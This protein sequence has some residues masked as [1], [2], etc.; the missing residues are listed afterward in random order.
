MKT[1]LIWWYIIHGGTNDISLNKV[2]TLRP[3]NLPMEI[4]DIY[5]ICKSFGIARI[6]NS[7]ILPR[8]DLE[9]LKRIDE[10]N[11][12]LKDLCGFYS[13][14]FIDNS[15]ITESNSDRDEIHLNKVGSCLLGQNLLVIL[16]NLFH[17]M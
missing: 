9:C 17:M 2:H 6:A 16:I 13:F 8:K 12:Y 3:H 5:N 10:T 1:N 7:S 14:S 4:T 15:S 11:N